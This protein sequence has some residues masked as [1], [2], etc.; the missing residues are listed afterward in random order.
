LVDPAGHIAARVSVRAV[1]HSA[2]GKPDFHIQYPIPPRGRGLRW[3][4][5][6]CRIKRAARGRAQKIT[7]ISFDVTK[8]F[9]APDRITTG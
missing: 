9:G 6:F 3:I 2:T 8:R 7:G 5:T 1:T 4:K